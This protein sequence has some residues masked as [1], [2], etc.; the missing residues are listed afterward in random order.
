MSTVHDPVRRSQDSLWQAVAVGDEAAVAGAALTAVDHG[1]GV[2]SVLLDVI[3]GVQRHIGEEWA[4][5]RLSVAREHA[6]TALNDRVITT[7]ASAVPRPQP[8]L[9]RVV[10]ACVDGE[11]H[12]LPARLLAEVLVLRG[13]HVDYL[14]GQLP[15]PYLIHHLRATGAQVV[16][17]SSSL[18][19]R[20][21]TAHAMITACQEAGT[22]VLVGGSAFGPRGQ[23][24][25][26]LGA[27]LWAPDA[28]TAGDLLAE[29]QIGR[30]HV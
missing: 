29:D 24:A 19:S 2:E 27:D 9:A 6:M 8:H 25:R 28:R 5:N 21:P 22:A 15:I 11:W 20:L 30:A 17:L 18:A 13:F 4:A 14:G 10:V 23:H 7:L 26:L 1:L 16:A 12:T 3:G